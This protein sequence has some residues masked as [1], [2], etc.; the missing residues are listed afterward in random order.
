MIPVKNVKALFFDVFGTLV[1]WRSGVAREA[2]SILQPLG[3]AIDW[4]A[5]LEAM[6]M[7]LPAICPA[8]GGISDL[9]AGRGWL[10][11]PGDQTSLERAMRAVME[12]PATIAPMG[13]LCRDYVRS[14]FDSRQIVEQYCKLLIS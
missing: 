10:T 8:V 11:V 14:N 13:A 9:L 6:A 4:I 1:D 12:D 2:R 3:Y 7:G 5:L